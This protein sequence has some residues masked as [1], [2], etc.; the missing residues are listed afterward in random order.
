MGNMFY[1]QSISP[2][3]DELPLPV[4]IFDHTGQILRCNHL[5]ERDIRR[6]LKGD[7]IG[8]LFDLNHLLDEV[9]QK[10]KEF[11]Q[12]ELH[13]DN[14]HSC[15]G[16]V[17]PC[18]DERQYMLIVSEHL[19]LP[20]IARQYATQIFNDINS[21]L[22]VIDTHSKVIEINRTACSILGIK[23]DELIGKSFMELFPNLPEENNILPNSL[24]EGLTVRNKAF[25]WTSAGNTYELLLDSHHLYNEFGEQAGAYVIFK[26]VSN[27]R[28]ISEKMQRSDRLSMIGQVAAGT[29]HEIRNPLTSIRG[30]LQIIGGSLV[31]AGMV[32]E[33]EYVDLMLTEIKRINSL[34]DQFLLLSKPR[35]I[36]YRV[37]DLNHV[38]KEI[39]PIIQ[40]EAILHNVEILDIT[41]GSLPSIIGDSELLKQVFLNICKNGVE[42]IGKKGKV[43]IDYELK[44]E[45][46]KV[47]INIHD[48]GPGI[49]P[50]VIDRLFDPFFTTKEEGT[51]LGLSVCQRIVQDLGGTIRVSSKGF[52]TT[53]HVILP[54]LE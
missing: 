42:A 26:D 5:F 30:F 2:L 39:I 13:F 11:L 50:Y 52:G 41:D 12:Y 54:Y 18:Q 23:K 14:W 32:K 25:T 47:S 20:S 38:L 27:L 29:A 17:V 3:I 35:D 15:N 36:Q 1:G 53:F 43:I 33:R 37:V 49:P 7:H 24:I 19:Q 16:L 22:I 9:H 21:G 51:G 45:E 4:V 8:S 48:T 40:N 44:H 46:K 28:T 6:L 34:V 10:Q 31:D